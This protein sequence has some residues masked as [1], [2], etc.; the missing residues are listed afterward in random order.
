MDQRL[1]GALAKNAANYSSQISQL[2][3]DFAKL[4]KSFSNLGT[5]PPPPPPAP[6]GAFTFNPPGSL[7]ASSSSAAQPS[8]SP[9]LCHLLSRAEIE[10]VRDG[11]EEVRSAAAFQTTYCEEMGQQ[12]EI[13]SQEVGELRDDLDDVR[14]D[15]QEPPEDTQQ[16]PV[17]TQNLPPTSQQSQLGHVWNEAT[18]AA[19]TAARLAQAHAEPH[20]VACPEMHSGA[21]PFPSQSPQGFSEPST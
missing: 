15:D 2:L 5:H 7:L 13:L 6:S 20:R 17:V 21:M 12:L 1:L 11:L 10:V 19:V 4:Y 16:F 14:A 9:F 18:A 3:G 8:P